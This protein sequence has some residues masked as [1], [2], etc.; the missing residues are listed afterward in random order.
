MST[1]PYTGTTPD[2]WP[3]ITE[4]LI[5]GHPLKQE[6]IVES[7]L[8]S[9]TSIFESTIGESFKI[10]T[11]LVLSPQSLGAFLHQLIPLQISTKYPGVWRG[12]QSAA[13]K[14][15]VHIPDNKYSIELKTSS[16]PSQIFGNRSYAQETQEGKKSKSGY[17]LTVNFNKIILGGS[18]PEISLIR[19]GWI[20]HTDW[21]GQS[22]Q[23]GQQSR[24][25]PIVYATKLKTLY[26]VKS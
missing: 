17:Y 2:Q 18:V 15:I 25:P 26:G 23:T 8:K 4:Q 9:W 14:D 19:F 6:E 16:H 20:D 10:G 21:I 24:L 22:S 11:H 3:A 1:S 12:E 7:V 13:D 5:L